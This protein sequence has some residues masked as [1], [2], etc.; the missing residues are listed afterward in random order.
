MM[1]PAA[2]RSGSILLLATLFAAACSVNA[3]HY[4]SDDAG[5]PPIDAMSCTPN[6]ITCDEASGRYVDCAS[7]GTPNVES[8]CALGCAPE[9]EKC[10]DVDPSN[11]LAPYLDQA[12][13]DATVIDVAFSGD[14]TINT[15]TGEVF[16][17]PRGIEVPH[18]DAGNIAV[19]MFKNLTVSGTLTVIGD[20]PIALV[21][22]YNVAIIGVISVAASG[23]TSGP[24]AASGTCEGHDFAFVTG[25]LGGGGG[26]GRHGTG[27]AGGNDNQGR[28]GGG[29]GNASADDDLIPLVGGCAGGGA[30][31]V[32]SGS[33]PPHCTGG[34]GGGAI[35]VVSRTQIS[36]TEGGRIDASGGGGTS[37]VSTPPGTVCGGGGGSGGGIL[38]EAPQVTLDGPSVVLSTK[39]GG[40]GAVG[41]APTYAGANGGTNPEPAAGGAHGTYP[42]GGAGGTESTAPFPGGN[43]NATSGYGAGGGGSVGETRINTSL[44]GVSPQH[45]ATIHSY[46][47]T[48]AVNTRL[49]P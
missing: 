40:G 44:G 14:S 43:A 36:L 45:G 47:S 4:T 15:M 27:G 30:S 8:D 25:N 39:G 31:Y 5:D 1:I 6:T 9:V 41:D 11:D 29:G 19:F 37:G 33:A 3:P 7:D 18:A 20:K 28:L 32:S 12:R 13:D 35:Q 24:G 48:G 21:A 23:E 16:N 34:G 10:V 42:A 38:L 46:L 22:E 49:T 26:A 17:G 2:A